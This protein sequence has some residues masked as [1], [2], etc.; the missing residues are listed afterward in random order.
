VATELYDLLLPFRAAI[1]TAQTTW[2][3]TVTHHLGLLATVLGR[4]EE[5]E[6]HFAEAVE[7]QD[8]IGVR[9]TVVHSRLEWARMLLRRAR[10]NDALP[11]RTL[12]E[13]AKVGAEKSDSPSSSHTSASC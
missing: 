1:I 8:R 11:V 7:L 2:I 9:G 13:E 4:Y 5:A 6:E 10:P 12:L 3:G